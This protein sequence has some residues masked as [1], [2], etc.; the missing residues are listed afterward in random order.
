MACR[1]TAESRLDN[2]TRLCPVSLSLSMFVYKFIMW[3]FRPSSSE[4]DHKDYRDTAYIWIIPGDKSLT[5][6]V[7]HSDILHL[8]DKS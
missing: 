2:S 7:H 4:R 6:F 3:P 8:V 5:H 1:N